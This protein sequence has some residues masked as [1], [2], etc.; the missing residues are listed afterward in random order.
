MITINAMADQFGIVKQMTQTGG[1][2]VVRL[3]GSQENRHKAVADC[4]DYQR[5]D[6]F[7]ELVHQTPQE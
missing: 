5:E 3:D 7:S 2:V 1:Q 4:V 6:N